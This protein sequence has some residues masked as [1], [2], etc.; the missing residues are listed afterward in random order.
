MDIYEYVFRFTYK[1]M[2]EPKYG[3]RDAAH[4]TG[5]QRDDAREFHVLGTSNPVILSCIVIQ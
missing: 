2:A 4:T 5:A 1:L 3:S